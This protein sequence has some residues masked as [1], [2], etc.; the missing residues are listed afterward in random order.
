M[1]QLQELDAMEYVKRMLEER[2]G[3][4]ESAQSYLQRRIAARRPPENIEHFT[5]YDEEVETAP[6]RLLE[7]GDI[8]TLL[9]HTPGVLG[10]ANELP[11]TVERCVE[12]DY[13]DIITTGHMPIFLADKYFHAPQSI[14]GS[15]GV[16]YRAE[17]EREAAMASRNG[18]ASPEL[19]PTIYASDIRRK[20]DGAT[21][22]PPGPELFNAYEIYQ[23]KR[24][25]FMPKSEIC[26][27]LQPSND[28]FS[29]VFFQQ[30][31]PKNKWND[32]AGIQLYSMN[33]HYHWLP[34]ETDI[35]IP[36]NLRKSAYYWYAF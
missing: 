15:I 12:E 35:T 5:P 17:M 30:H 26:A 3:E 16:D 27:K 14:E 9:K 23:L 8:A 10:F 34:Y 1:S 18:K 29:S 32:L 24:V 22:K 6:N 25:S 19:Y 21:T 31:L 4:Y 36:S 2:D 13:P 28:I 7:P 11:R 20:E 33:N